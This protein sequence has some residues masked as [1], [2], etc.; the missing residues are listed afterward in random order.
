MAYKEKQ[1]TSALKFDWLTPL[2][3]YVMPLFPQYRRLLDQL[4]KQAP[5]HA[6]QRILDVGCG[7]GEFLRRLKIYY[8]AIDAVGLDIDSH[9]LK[10]AEEKSKEEKQSIDYIQ[11]SSNELPFSD[12]SFHLVFS[13]LLFH[14]LSMAEKEQT[15]SEIYRILKEDGQA[16]ILDFGPPR[17]SAINVGFLA[18]Q[19]FD[20]IENVR[21]HGKNKF[22]DLML[23]SPFSHVRLTDHFDTPIGTLYAYQL[24]K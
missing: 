24:I 2:Y 11:G 21:P 17:N 10:I 5:I 3:A 16:H 19:I 15:L 4:I 13:T 14:H 6:G 9:I 8:P 12:T 1:Y 22:I 7:P 18:L 20:G 23:A